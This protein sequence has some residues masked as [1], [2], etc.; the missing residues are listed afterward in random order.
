MKKT[1]FKL[2]LIV[3]LL[4]ASFAFAA[5]I[6]N[7]EILGLNAISRGTVLS[8]LP[9]EVG[10]DYN[11]STSAQI[12]RALYKTQFFKD[13]EVTQTDQI[14]KIQ[15]TENPHIKYIELLNRSDKVIDEDALNQALASMN[16]VQ[17]KIF[18]EREL[19]ELIK[20]LKGS[21]IA[22]GYY[23]IK[24]TKKVEVDKQN[25]VGIELD[26]SEGDVARI[27]S[28]KITGNKAEKA[29]DLLDLFTI[30][31][32]DFFIVNYFT[33]RDYYSKVAFDAGIEALKSHYI[34]LGYLDFKVLETQVDLSEDK[35]SIN[36]TVQIVEGDRYKIGKITFI[37]NTL[38]HSKEALSKLL[39]FKSGDLFERKKIIES[40]NKIT[41]VYTNAGHAFTEVDASTFKEEKQH[42][43]GLKFK[44][45]PGQKTYVNRI[46]ITGNTRTQDEV[47]RREISLFEGGLYSD[48]ELEE[49]INK[50]KRLG[51]FSDVKMNISKIKG[52]EDKININFSVTETKTGTF[53]IGLS[54]SNSAGAS[55]NVGIEE[56]NFLG[57]GNTLNALVSSSKAVQEVNVYFLDPYFTQDGHSISYG[58]FSKQTDGEELSQS[59]Y[60][61]DEQGVKIGYG[62]P[63]TK[64]TRLNINL[65]A[66]IKDLECGSEYAGGNQLATVADIQANWTKGTTNSPIDLEDDDIT[67]ATMTDRDAWIEKTNTNPDFIVTDEGVETTNRVKVYNVDVREITVGYE[68]AQCASGD[69]NEVKLS[70]GWSNNTLDDFNFPTEGAANSLKLEVALPIGDFKYYKLNASHKS[71]HKLGQHATWKTSASMGLGQGYGDKEL[72]FFERYYGGGSSSVRGFDFNSLGA[73]YSGSDKVTGGELSILTGASIVSPLTFIKDSSNMRMSAFVDAGGISRKPEDFE[74]DDLRASA[75]VAFSWLTPVGPLGFYAAT[76]LI[77]KAGDKIKTFEFTLGTTF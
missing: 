74:G 17:G 62:V 25:R 51:F 19:D 68:T 56:R 50:I 73:K 11:D 21:Y 42:I 34:N 46:T 27:K 48:E 9:V 22:K 65:S 39:T 64:D 18:N 36:V 10:D 47:V 15:I 59:S 4:S 38:N 35:K 44:I 55:F 71:Y 23:G 20:Q 58:V 3:S 66:S 60:N 72:P 57:T 7:I 12:I 75:G 30:G 26:L 24:I 69:K 45:V 61:I 53:S 33:E 6:K 16:L 49:S 40:I 5:P 2:S 67:E 28:M 14:L 70:V 76:P 31:E 77:K 13:I 37:G 52:F 54:H 1:V 43:I 63:I 29:S 32:P 8:Y 41:R